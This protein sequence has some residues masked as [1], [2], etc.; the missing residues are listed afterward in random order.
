M[1]TMRQCHKFLSQIGGTKVPLVTIFRCLLYFKN[2]F[3]IL[4]LNI[5]PSV[6]FSDALS[7]NKT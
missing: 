7:D 4:L 1:K 3:C 5:L 2:C 6:P